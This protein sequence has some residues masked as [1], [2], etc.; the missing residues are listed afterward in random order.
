[1]SSY[2]TTKWYRSRRRIIFGVCQGLANWKKL[3]VGILRLIIVIALLF[4]NIPI[5]IIIV[6]AYISLGI[7]LPPEPQDVEEP[8][9]KK[10]FFS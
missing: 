1:M 2:R 3:P 8:E 9:W 4:S 5:R 10:R 6:I 7:F